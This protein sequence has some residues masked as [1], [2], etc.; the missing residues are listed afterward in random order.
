MGS[1]DGNN[2]KGLALDDSGWCVREE[3]SAET[4][5]LGDAT[6]QII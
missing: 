3:P 6:P 1:S 2:A 4:R 5:G